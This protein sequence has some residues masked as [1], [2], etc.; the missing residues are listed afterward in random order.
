[1]KI[2]DKNKRDSEQARGATT[3]R[4]AVARYSFTSVQATTC[5]VYFQVTR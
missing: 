1:M 5:H 3:I 2:I 4:P